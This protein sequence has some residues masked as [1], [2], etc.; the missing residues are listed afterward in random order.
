MTPLEFAWCLTCLFLEGSAQ[1][2][3]GSSSTF[4]RQEEGF[5]SANVGSSITLPCFYNEG[6]VMIYWFKQTVGQKP[7]VVVTF[8]KHDEHGTFHNEHRN[9]SRLALEVGNGKTHLR[10][11]DLHPSDS[12]TYYCVAIDSQTFEFG[13]GA[14]VSVE[15]SGSNIHTLVHQTV[16]E[17]N[18]PGGSLT[19]DCTVDTGS[20]NEQ[21]SFYW[22]KE[23][24]GAHPGLIYSHGGRSDQCNRTVMTPT[25]IC[26][27]SLPLKNLNVSQDGT[28]RCAVASCGHLLFEDWKNMESAGELNSSELLVHFLIGALTFTIILSA[29]MAFSI[30]RMK[31]KIQ[32]HC[33]ANSDTGPADRCTAHSEGNPDEESLQYSVLRQQRFNGTR[34]KRDDQCVYSSVKQS[35]STCQEHSVTTY[36]PANMSDDVR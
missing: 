31:R 18:H 30:C 4:I 16:S 17:T 36:E 24:R 35:K 28:N 9:N 33:T 26:D 11:S 13:D 27:Y 1:N 10:I 14:T 6:A 19:L 12:A 23:A 34:R 29:W 21:Y 22:F 7:D 20:Y 25:Y 32:S 15:G 8:Y 3:G 5:H 2:T